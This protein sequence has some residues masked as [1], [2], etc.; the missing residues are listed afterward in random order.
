VKC[1]RTTTHYHPLQPI[2]PHSRPALT[3]SGTYDVA[4]TYKCYTYLPPRY[5][6]H[7][8]P[9]LAP[10]WHL[11][12][13]TRHSSTLAHNHEFLRWHNN[14]SQQ[15]VP[16]IIIS[17]ILQTYFYTDYATHNAPIHIVSETPWSSSPITYGVRILDQLSAL[18]VPQ[19]PTIT[20]HAKSWTK[21]VDHSAKSNI[22]VQLI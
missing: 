18:H 1:V 13:A 16:R 15:P 11:T 21:K 2:L 20:A 7:I 22:L 12:L 17:I 14:S 3:P 6:R 4:A 8:S 19:S 9:I 10:G 5:L